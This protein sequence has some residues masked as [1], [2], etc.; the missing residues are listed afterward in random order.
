MFPD[1]WIDLDDSSYLTL[2]I[3]KKFLKK[4]SP[5]N[6]VIFKVGQILKGIGNEKGEM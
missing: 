2:R 1:N 6:G 5:S 3:F 4:L